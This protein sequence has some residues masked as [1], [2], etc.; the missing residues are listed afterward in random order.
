M[1]CVVAII[2]NGKIFMGADSFATTG[3]G[4]R[5]PII[6][7]KLFFNKEY[8]IGFTGSVRTGRLL[9]PDYF[10]PPAKIEEFADA[11]REH[12]YEKGCVLVSEE[13]GQIQGS[14]FLIGYQGSI[15][16]M[17]IDFQMNE[18]NEDS[19]AIGAGANFAF[20]SLF[21]TRKSMSITPQGRIMMAL[22]AASHYTTSVGP[23]FVYES[24]E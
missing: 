7:N 22:S 15:H 1:S 23:P 12:L 13:H 8:L 21:T 9:G 4:E 24:I 2:D 18:V 3:E 17:L 14:N 19:D 6:A 11:S 20:G 10:N 16:E 5:R